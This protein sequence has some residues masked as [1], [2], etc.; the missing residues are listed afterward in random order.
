MQPKESFSSPMSDTCP[1]QLVV[2]KNKHWIL[3][4]E[5]FSITVQNLEVCFNNL[6]SSDIFDYWL[7]NVNKSGQGDITGIISDSTVHL[8]TRTSYNK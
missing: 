1:Y 7:E 5:C 6:A 3:G 8:I 4:I 2:H